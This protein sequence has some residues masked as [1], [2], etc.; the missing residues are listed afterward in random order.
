MMLYMGIRILS[1][2]VAIISLGLG[3]LC[4]QPEQDFLSNIFIGIFTG[5]IL[6]YATSF[7]SYRIERRNALLSY[8]G[9]LQAY[10]ARFNLLYNNVK[11]EREGMPEENIIDLNL[12]FYDLHYNSYLK[13][14]HICKQRKLPKKIN[15]VFELI[16]NVQTEINASHLEQLEQMKKD[17]DCG[18]CK[19]ESILR[20][21]GYL[22]KN[23]D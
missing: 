18:V 22:Q 10:R 21:F 3:F 16:C 7:M 1:F 20:D 4:Y 17:V 19:L 13:I 5:A 12:Y 23:K 8:L 14:Q 11:M 9:A 15:E 2:F 6:T